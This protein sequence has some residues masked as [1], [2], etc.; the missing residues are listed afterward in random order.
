MPELTPDPLPENI[1][2]LFRGPL[3]VCP[4]CGKT[5]TPRRANHKYCS[6]TCRV[7]WFQRKPEHDRR[8]RDAQIRLL[9]RTA[10]ETI[11]KATLLLRKPLP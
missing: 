2:T 9:L 11:Q 7:V 1:P 10:S 4:G 5:F 8:D 6:T 3:V